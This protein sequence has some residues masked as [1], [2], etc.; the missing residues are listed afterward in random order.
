[1]ALGAV[2]IGF[3]VRNHRKQKRAIANSTTVQGTVTGI[4]VEE[5]SYSEGTTY[6]PQLEYEYEYL[7]ESYTGDDLYPG[8]LD[9]GY[10]TEKKAREV[11]DEFTEGGPISLYV[12]TDDPSRSFVFRETTPVRNVGAVFAGLVIIGFGLLIA[13]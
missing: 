12:D 7:G 9:S 1:M 4:D 8:T 6:R 3:G 13:L 10:N 5:D 2:S 11:L